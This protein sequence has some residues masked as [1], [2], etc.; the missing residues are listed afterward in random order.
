MTRYVALLR[1]VNVGGVRITMPALGDT[2]RE[3]GLESVRTVLASG[4]VVFDAGRVTTADLKALTERALRDRFGY[5]AWV[6]VLP[7]SAVRAIVADYPFDTDEAVCHPYV[8]F[9][10]DPGTVAELAEHAAAADDDG[11]RLARGDGVVYWEAPRGGS[12]TTPFAR[13]VA[14]ARFKPLVTTRN[15]RTLRKLG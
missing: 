11:E 6:H 15:L 4:N 5:D 9:C 13:L 3:L 14:K 12:T 1:G 2:F 7:L 10:A 8:V